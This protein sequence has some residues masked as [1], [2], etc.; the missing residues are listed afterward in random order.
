MRRGLEYILL[1][2]GILG[3][4]IWLGSVAAPKVWEFLDR[5]QVGPAAGPDAKP[6]EGALIGQLR[7]P[8]LKLETPVR[9]GTSNR[10]L[11]IAAGR[12]EGTALP[13]QTGNLGIAAHRDTIFRPLREI[14]K[15]DRIE[16]ETA[17]GRHEYAVASTQVVAP[18]DVSVLASSTKPEITLVTCYPFGYFGHAPQRFVVKA[19]EVEQYSQNMFSAPNRGT[20]AKKR[21]RNESVSRLSRRNGA[22]M[23]GAAQ[24]S[25]RRGGAVRTVD[26]ESGFASARHTAA[27]RP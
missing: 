25:R 23:A 15:G 8:R 10:T 7:I 14:R 17:R 3:V 27:S 6:P 20:V 21:R 2:A 24:R 22:K 4:A 11:L 16:F 12:I 9:E 19:A 1:F 5:N 26:G 18:N 13:G